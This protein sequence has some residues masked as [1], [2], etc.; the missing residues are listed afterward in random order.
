MNHCLQSARART[1][2]D[3]AAQGWDA[4]WKHS[5]IRVHVARKS[6][7][8]CQNPAQLVLESITG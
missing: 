4:W 7:T 3:G 2:K 6:I 8:G 1:D 5:R